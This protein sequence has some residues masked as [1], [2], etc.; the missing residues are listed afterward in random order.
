MKFAEF[1]V[2]SEQIR[3]IRLILSK[4]FEDVCVVFLQVIALLIAVYAHIINRSILLNPDDKFLSIKLSQTF[5]QP[6]THV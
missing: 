2:R 3:R 4:H 5:V 1:L 6:K